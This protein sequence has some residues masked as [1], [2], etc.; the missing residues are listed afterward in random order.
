[1]GLS[2]IIFI[3]A[4]LVAA[5][6]LIY[7]LKRVKHKF[8]AIF[9]II[10][11]LFSFLSFNAVFGGKEVS[12]QNISDLGNVAKLYFFWLGNIFV[13]LKSITSNAVKMDWQGNKTDKTT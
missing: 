13:N 4:I 9:L 12:I 3:I 11:I 1:M 8:L 7:G 6:W 10:L 2:V 5:I